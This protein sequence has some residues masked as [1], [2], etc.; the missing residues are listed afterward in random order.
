[1]NLA[2]IRGGTVM[3]TKKICGRNI[4]KLREHN[5]FTQEKLVEEMKLIDTKF[6]IE[7]LRKIEKFERNTI[8]IEIV[9]FCKIFNISSDKLLNELV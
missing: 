4:K 6:S 3:E 2:L 8:D 5:N 1:M 9:G 7:K